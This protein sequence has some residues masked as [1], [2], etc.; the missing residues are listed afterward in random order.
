ML[1]INIIGPHAPEDVKRLV[2][3]IEHHVRACPGPFLDAGCA[4][5]SIICRCLEI[6]ETFIDMHL[7]MLVVFAKR[8]IEAP[9]KDGSK[10]AKKNQII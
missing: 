5:L 2:H 10:P 4:H 9:P 1:P 6:C 3:G 7:K 8:G